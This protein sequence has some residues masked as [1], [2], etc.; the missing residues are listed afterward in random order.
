[1]FL[2]TLSSGPRTAA[3]S[4]DLGDVMESGYE[5]TTRLAEENPEW[6]LVT[7]ACY[8]FSVQFGNR[9]AGSWI[10]ERAAAGWFPNLKP[11]VTRG[12]LEKEYSTRGGRRGYYKLVD[13]E[14][15]GR[16]LK[17]LGLIGDQ[18]A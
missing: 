4:L 10:F 17:Q 8:E 14:G 12:I 3:R 11:L 15:T 18:A 9:F 5:A 2:S 7:K 6:M 13:P 1:M 16:A